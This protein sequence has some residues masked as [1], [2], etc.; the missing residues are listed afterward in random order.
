MALT[1]NRHLCDD[2]A[3]VL[4][5]LGDSLYLSVFALG[6]YLVIRHY[7]VF[8]FFIVFADLTVFRE[9]QMASLNGVQWKV[10]IQPHRQHHKLQKKNKLSF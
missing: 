2:Y 1:E 6:D 7:C 3:L 5:D 4:L 10:V 9:T 8:Q